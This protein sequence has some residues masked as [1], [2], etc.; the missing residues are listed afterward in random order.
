MLLE[1]T[2]CSCGC[3]LFGLL[4]D[5]F[6]D[7]SRAWFLSLYCFFFCYYPLKGWIHGKL[8]CEFVFLSWNTLVSPS[9]VIESLAG[10]SS[11]GWHL[12]SLSVCIAS[13]QDLLFFIV[14]GE[15]SGV[16]LIGLPL[17]VT[18]HCSL[19][20][21]NSISLFSAFLLLIIMC[22]EECLFWSSLYGIL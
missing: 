2:F 17:Y 10:Y 20:T 8:M 14:S 15:K 7:F 21:F 16:I 18:W 12:C 19:T 1:F 5:Y 9:I 3:L 11:L 4:R 22:Q 6:I 13:V